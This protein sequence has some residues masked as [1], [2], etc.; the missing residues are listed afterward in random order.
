VTAS[1]VPAD[2]RHR[3]TP[4]LR[5]R[6]TTRL[7]WLWLGTVSSG[8]GSLT[9]LVATVL[10]LLAITRYGPAVLSAWTTPWLLASSLLLTLGGVSLLRAA[11][12]ESLFVSPTRSGLVHQLR[13]RKLRLHTEFL[14]WEDV[15]AIH[16]GTIRY[17]LGRWTWGRRNLLRL[18]DRQGA[19]LSLPASLAGLDRVGAH[20]KAR[21]YPTL[22]A[23]GR[24]RFNK[25][26]S[27]TFGPL[28][29]DRNGL[30]VKRRA[31]A[32]D[33]LESAVVDGGILRLTIRRGNRTRI[34]QLPVWKIAN[35]D[36]C[37]QILQHLGRHP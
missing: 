21:A 23:E 15:R 29:L 12:L 19:S 1:A 16:A 10:T 33:N 11:W 28:R 14:P 13:L 18:V 36:L 35:L 24:E 8:L 30:V 17:G 9:T 2:R 31:V 7:H 32:W 37:L 22:L 6:R 5:I 3:S 27:L 26:E 25:G 20:V 4:V 34:I